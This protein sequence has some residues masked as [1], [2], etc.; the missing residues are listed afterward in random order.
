MMTPRKLMKHQAFLDR[1]G[2]GMRSYMR[3][4]GLL[5]FVAL[6]ILITG[7]G[8]IAL[9]DMQI[10]IGY[11]FVLIAVAAILGFTGTFLTY[12]YKVTQARKAIAVA[13]A[14]RGGV[15]FNQILTNAPLDRTWNDALPVSTS[16]PSTLATPTPVDPASA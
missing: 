3:R 11:L 6:T 13:D 4:E 8:A 12:S 14:E 7:T 16:T 1:Y 2:S 10:S 15:H 9:S 5:L